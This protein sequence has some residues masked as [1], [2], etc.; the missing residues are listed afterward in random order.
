MEF[1]NSLILLNISNSE[2]SEISF[3][4]LYRILSFNKI[5][6]TS[7]IQKCKNLEEVYFTHNIL[8]GVATLDISYN[9][10]SNCGDVPGLLYWIYKETHFQ[11]TQRKYHHRNLF[12]NNSLVDKPGLLPY[13]SL[14]DGKFW[15]KYHPVLG[16]KYLYYKEYNNRARFSALITFCMTS[17]LMVSV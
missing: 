12:S 14:L 3:P 6:R 2:F 4:K 11:A 5:R 7:G 10:I 15:I 8:I 13:K 16:S 9:S 1:P 17:I